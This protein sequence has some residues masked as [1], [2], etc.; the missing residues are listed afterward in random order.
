MPVPSRSPDRSCAARRTR[1]STCTPDRAYPVAEVSAAEAALTS[2]TDRYMRAA[3]YAVA[4][5]CR[6]ELRRVRGGVAG[7]RVLALVGGGSNGAD[8][9]LA[10][11]LLARRGC[12]VTALLGTRHPLPWAVEEARQ[13]GVAV[14]EATASSA[15]RPAGCADPAD[16]PLSEEALAAITLVRREG[17]VVLDGLTGTGGA[18]PLRPQAAALVAPFVTEELAGDAG[19]FCEDTAGDLSQ[20]SAGNAGT[21]GLSQAGEV[22]EG[23]GGQAPALATP[24]AVGAPACSPGLRGRG[25]RVVAVDLPS[26]TDADDGTL[27]GP[28]LPADRTVTFTCLK[29][30]LCL[31]PACHLAGEV[32]VVDLGL[33]VP[34][35]EPIAVLPS[36]A[37]LSATLRAPGPAD[38]KYTRGVV[39]LWA[40]SHSYPGAAV[41]AASA[42]VR[43]GAG[44]VRLSAPRRVEDLV[45]ARRPEVVPG[46]GRCQA[47]VVGPG[48]EPQDRPRAYALRQVLRQVLAQVGCE[49][50]PGGARA[51][52]G[53]GA[54]RGTGVSTCAAP[55][56]IDAGALALLPGLVDEGLA[57]GPEHVLTPHAGEAARLLTSLGSPWSREQVSRQPL[58][59]AQELTGLT[60]ATTV[61]KG[62]VT[63]VVT[64][65]R[66]AVSV[67]DAPGWLATAGSGD[68]L[69][70]VLGALLAAA[71]ARAEQGGPPLSEVVGTV[72]SSAVRLHAQAGVVA[73]R[74]RDPGAGE[75]GEGRGAGRSTACPV[76]HPVAALDLADALPEAW[77]TLVLGSR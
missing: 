63:L 65:G 18:G 71:A 33:P 9:L 73:A 38:H 70:G 3:A 32:E 17:G 28:V 11:A 30:A 25:W 57:C 59:A 58:A 34:Q 4:R 29:G 77:A 2:G 14:V 19:G 51:P 46:A 15:S 75:A 39:G 61:L 24:A 31:P 44:M 72:V 26:G 49:H 55:A 68:V 45:L 35:G 69:A 43:A 12:A 42:A 40:G 1:S 50:P 27:P 66:P 21:T 10:C 56:V 8:T 6:A 5:A 16:L 13:T 64:P 62:A 54:P 20:D 37:D 23:T 36:W 67:R 53:A 60:G 76:G 47:R 52:R 7:G 22:R 74:R 41:L 48:T